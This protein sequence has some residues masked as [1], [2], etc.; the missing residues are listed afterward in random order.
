MSNTI[1][2]DANITDIPSIKN[3]YLNSAEYY[4]DNLILTVE[5]ITDDYILNSLSNAITK[6]FAIVMEKDSNVIG[7]IQGYPSQ[8]VREA[9]LIKDTR[10]IIHNQYNSSG[11][12]VKLM[13]S[14]RQKMNDMPHI[15]ALLFNVREHNIASAKCLKFFGCY[16]V[17]RYHD[18]LL[19]CDGSFM[20]D[21]VYKW[22]NPSFKITS[23]QH[24][25]NNIRTKPH[26]V[27][28]DLTKDS[29]MYLTK[30]SSAFRYA[31]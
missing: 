28:V 1:I 12:A 6:G 30:T 22:D 11:Y 9:H 27:Y 15:K 17:C 25:W 8:N 16:E 29:L 14:V 19:K 5:E 3:L 13:S 26:N 10:V 24:Y 4:P 20:D 31:S 23:F 7:Y 21:V 18:A 2:R